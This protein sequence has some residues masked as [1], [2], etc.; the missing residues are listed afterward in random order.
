MLDEQRS[1]VLALAQP[2]GLPLCFRPAALA[3]TRAGPPHCAIPA[4]LDQ[5]PLTAGPTQAV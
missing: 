1:M 4:S 3:M 5:N 2:E